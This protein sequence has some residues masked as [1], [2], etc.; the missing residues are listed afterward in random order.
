MWQGIKLPRDYHSPRRQ[1]HRGTAGR[2]LCTPGLQTSGL[3]PCQ[4][5][6]LQ[7]ESFPAKLLL[8]GGREGESSG[9]ATNTDVRSLLQM[10]EG[11]GTWFCSLLVL[12][13]GKGTWLCPLLVLGAGLVSPPIGAGVG[14]WAG[15]DA[16]CQGGYP[17]CP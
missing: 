3:R 6:A 14:N 11:K 12:G 13:E 1:L 7:G 10:G 5:P 16:E 8:S 2:T 4:A 9:I 17:C 15:N